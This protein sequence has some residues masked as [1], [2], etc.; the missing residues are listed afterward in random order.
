MENEERK[1][2]VIIVGG[3]VAGLTLAHCLGKSN[4]EYAVLESHHDIAPEVGA[5]IGIL[6]NGA[7]ILDQLDVFDDILSVCEPLSKSFYWTEDGKLIMENDSPLTIHE[8]YLF[9]P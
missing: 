7:R 4:I 5:S 8:R 1:F 6:P 3:S 9:A 2:R